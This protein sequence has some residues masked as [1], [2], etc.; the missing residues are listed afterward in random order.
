MKNNCEWVQVSF[1]VK[2]FWN[3]IAGM[4]VQL[5]EYVQKKWS[6][7]YFRKVVLI[8]FLLYLN[9]TKLVLAFPQSYLLTL[10]LT[11]YSLATM[12]F[13]LPPQVYHVLSYPKALAYTLLCYKIPF[14]SSLP[15]SLSFMIQDG[16]ET[17]LLHPFRKPSSMP[18]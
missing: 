5:C 14:P 2:L 18:C 11:C 8:V 15:K 13:P 7:V 4:V 9:E 1:W 17:L 12:V 3:Q 10:S 16:G 6:V